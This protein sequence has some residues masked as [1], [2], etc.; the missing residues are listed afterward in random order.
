MK[1][2]KHFYIVLTVSLFVSCNK[3]PD[4]KNPSLSIDKRVDDLLSRMTLEEKV[5]Q[6]DMLSAN[7]ILADS[8][9]LNE[10]KAYSYIDSMNIGSI[11]DLY[12]QLL[13]KPCMVIRVRVQPLSQFH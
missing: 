11:H 13:K 12:P 3:L 6:M 4:Y 8:R 7:N 2:F 5:A 10:S 9:T 1:I